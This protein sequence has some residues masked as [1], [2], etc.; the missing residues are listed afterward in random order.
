MDAILLGVALCLGC[1]DLS[2]AEP[3]RVGQVF[4][5][6]NVKTKDNGIREELELYPGQRL[7]AE[8]ELLKAEIRL[9]MKYHKRFDLA[10][11]KRPRIKVLPPPDEETMFRDVWVSFPEKPRKKA[12]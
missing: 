9:L 1:A 12:R 7:P 2:E 11:G 6:G 5:E 4:I 10:A 3:P 8:A